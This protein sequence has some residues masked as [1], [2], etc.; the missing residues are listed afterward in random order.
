MRSGTSAQPYAARVTAMAILHRTRFLEYEFM[1]IKG[2]DGLGAQSEHRP[3]NIH[4]IVPARCAQLAFAIHRQGKSRPQSLP[5][6]NKSRLN[7]Q[8]KHLNSHQPTPT[9]IMAAAWSSSVPDAASRSIGCRSAQHLVNMI[10]PGRS[11]IASRKC[12]PENPRCK[13]SSWYAQLKL[14]A[15]PRRCASATMR[16]NS[17]CTSA[18]PACAEINWLE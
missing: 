3:G 13:P 10:S 12:F 5:G 7:K 1:G 4:G 16:D 8:D 17:V 11:E 2:S 15:S 18:A 14:V 6:P 9:C